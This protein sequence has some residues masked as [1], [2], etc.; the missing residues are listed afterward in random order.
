MGA[1]QSSSNEKSSVKSSKDSGKKEKTIN[2]YKLGKTLGEGTFAEVRYAE[3]IDGSGEAAIKIL[4]DSGNVET[5]QNE[6]DCMKA[7]PHENAIKLFG[8]ETEV[9]FNGSSVSYF[10]LELA[11]NGE[12]FQILAMTGAFDEDVARL[13]AKQLYTVIGFFHDN[14]I[15]HRDLKPENILLDDKCTIKVADFGLATKFNE[16]ECMTELVGSPGYIAPEVYAGEYLHEND[17]WAACVI[18]FIMMTGCPPFRRAEDGDWWYNKLR[19][20]KWDRWWKAHKKNSGVTLSDDAKDLFQ[21]V[22]Q[23]ER[24][25]RP[26]IV[27]I[28]K[29]KWFQGE[30]CSPDD[31]MSRFRDKMNY[32]YNDYDEYEAGEDMSEETHRGDETKGS[33]DDPPPLQSL[34][35]P[36]RA[37]DEKVDVDTSGQNTEVNRG[38]EGDEDDT[39]CKDAEV[40]KN[41]VESYTKFRSKSKPNNIYNILKDVIKDIPDTTFLADDTRPYAMKV[42]STGEDKLSYRIQV[43]SEDKTGNS[44]LDMTRTS[45]SIRS[46]MSSYAKIRIKFDDLILQD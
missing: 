40:Y 2:D 26:P 46:Y 8:A 42:K 30:T 20:K 45:G 3:A 32:Q 11:K 36:R 35:L 6:I 31:L 21:T 19:D 17:I 29:H 18:H 4:F 13:F 23:I 33:D 22:F 43:F 9:D 10:I 38:D 14:K 44:I 39:E 7:V 12:L 37:A 41:V 34:V 28:L 24:T 5:I 15:T 27:D 1:K 16:N 25:K